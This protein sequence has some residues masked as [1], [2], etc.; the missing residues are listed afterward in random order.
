[1]VNWSKLTTEERLRSKIKI[2]PDTGCWEWTGGTVTG[3]YGS[4]YFEGKNRRAHRVSYEVFCGQIPDGFDVC[5]HCDNPPCINPEHLF[6]GTT[7][8]NIAD[9]FAK[10]RNSCVRGSE[11]HL[12]KLSEADVVAIREAKGFLLR[13]LAVKFGVHVSV[14]SKIRKGKIWSHVTASQPVA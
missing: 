2:D 5:H 4:F 13:E 12:S 10:G 1:M 8:A 6:V 7:A 9:M 11:Q 3:G 14:I